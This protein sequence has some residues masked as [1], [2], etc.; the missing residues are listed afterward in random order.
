MPQDVD[1]VLLDGKFKVVFQNG[2][3]IFHFVLKIFGKT[4][5]TNLL[6]VAILGLYLKKKIISNKKPIFLQLR[7]ENI[8]FS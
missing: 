1:L 7:N 2:S 3:E 4:D 5:P 6:M 8:F